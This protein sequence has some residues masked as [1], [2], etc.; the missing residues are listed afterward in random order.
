[1]HTTNISTSSNHADGSH[2]P[3][4]GVR[5]ASAEDLMVAMGV[6]DSSSLQRQL[7]VLSHSLVNNL[8]ITVEQLL[9]LHNEKEVCFSHCI[10]LLQICVIV[11]SL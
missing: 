7:S 9:A 10:D 2:T 5:H 8:P 6:G 1:V 11:K 3:Q 4:I